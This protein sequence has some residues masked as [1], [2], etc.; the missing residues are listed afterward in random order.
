VRIYFDT[1]VFIDYLSARGYA[2]GLRASTRRGRVP[3]HIAA[4]AERLFEKVGPAHRGAT[5]CLTYYEVEEALY[6]VLAQSGKG[7]SRTD[8]FLVPVARSITTQLQMMVEVFNISVLDLT[9]ATVRV[10]LQQIDLQI[11]GIRAADA[12]H[13][14]SAIGFDA[15]LLVSTDDALLQLDGVLANTRG[16]KIVCRDTNLALQHLST[17]NSSGTS[18]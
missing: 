8:A 1:G 9:S 13:A 10:Q 11:R 18:S 5:S 2:F 12:L 14:A 16:H 7:V 17:L 6:R 4:D 3:A 15:D